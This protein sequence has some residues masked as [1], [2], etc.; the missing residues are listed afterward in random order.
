MGGSG[1]AGPERDDFTRGEV[2]TS[3]DGSVSTQ[4]AF[5]AGARRHAMCVQCRRRADLIV[6][7]APELTSWQ[8][9]EQAWQ[10]AAPIYIRELLH[11]HR[12]SQWMPGQDDG[13]VPPPGVEKS[14]RIRR[15]QGM[16]LEI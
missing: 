7:R 12:S 6:Y 8:V 16:F 3:V 15:V 5:I 11:R 14:G 13:G 4:A 10:G 2:W 1:L 9:C